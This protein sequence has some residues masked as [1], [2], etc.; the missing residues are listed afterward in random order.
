MNRITIVTAIIIACLTAA[1]AST[2][3]SS[4][5][6]VERTIAHD[7]AAYVDAFIHQDA[8][9]IGAMYAPDGVYVGAGGRTVKGREA[10]EST[11]RAAFAKQRLI[12]G[13][14][15]TDRVDLTAGEAWETGHCDYLVS[16]N[17]K[18]SKS[19]GR[20]LTL[21]RIDPSGSMTILVDV[22]G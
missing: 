6:S 19:G 17:G 18:T 15:L 4:Q 14:C 22:N 21:W 12:S 2:A 13:T 10:I 9:A 1:S 5:T 8:A 11:M 20:Y 16:K 3:A 7:N